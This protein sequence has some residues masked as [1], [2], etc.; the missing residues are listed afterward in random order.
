MGWTLT[1]DLIIGTFD[2]TTTSRTPLGVVI[3]ARAIALTTASVPSGLAPVMVIAIVSRQMISV[4]EPL[5]IPVALG[6]GILSVI[7]VAFVFSPLFLLIRGRDG[8]FNLIRPLG[9]VFCG[10]LYPVTFLAPEAEVVSRF[11]PVSWAMDAVLLAI[12][13]KGSGL[14][15][16]RKLGIALLLCGAY[17]AI[18]YL[19]LRKLD[20]RMRV[21][22]DLSRF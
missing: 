21:N 3:F 5:V 19:L 22:G 1:G 11:L 10:F 18:S 13:T 16:F 17:L 14:E 4:S 6:V 9:V 2:Y 12:E 20:H 7:S 15:A 8:L